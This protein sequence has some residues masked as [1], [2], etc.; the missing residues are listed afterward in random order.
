MSPSGGHLYA[1]GM[2]GNDFYSI[3]L[4]SGAVPA[5]DKAVGNL[6]YAIVLA[7]DGTRAYVSSWG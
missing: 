5:A 2:R 3:D 4:A 7:P 6:P 1:F